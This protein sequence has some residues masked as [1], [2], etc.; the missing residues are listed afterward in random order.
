MNKFIITSPEI[1]KNALA[2]VMEIMK[3][4]NVEVI[5][6]PH[7][8]AKTEEQRSWFH[9]LCRELCRDT[10]H[11]EGEIKEAVKK[12]ILGTHFIR[13]GGRQWEVTGSSEE[14]KKPQYS[15]LIEGVYHLAGE[16]GI[17]LPD[18]R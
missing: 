4:D 7:V 12:H 10:G 3:E 6:Q 1:K 5:I 16:A 2:A 14:C 13:I 11:T 18:P 17:P 15:E 9:I 8:D